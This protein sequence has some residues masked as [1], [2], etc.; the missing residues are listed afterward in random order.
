M[1]MGCY[2]SFTASPAQPRLRFDFQMACCEYA[3][4]GYGSE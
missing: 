4:D 3:D 1:A 2:R